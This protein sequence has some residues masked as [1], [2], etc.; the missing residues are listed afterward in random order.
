MFVMKDV[1]NPKV[2]GYVLQTTFENF[3]CSHHELDVIDSWEP[4][5]EF[6]KEELLVRWQ[7]FAC[8]KLHKVAEVVPA[9][10]VL[11]SNLL[12]DE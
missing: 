9:T 6:L 2:V 4:Y 1:T 5:P 7:R 8:Q 12:R 10:H 11:L 3:A